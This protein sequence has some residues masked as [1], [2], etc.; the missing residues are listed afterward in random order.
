MKFKKFFLTFGHYE[1]LYGSEAFKGLHASP[2][3]I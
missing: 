2:V 1:D 3:E